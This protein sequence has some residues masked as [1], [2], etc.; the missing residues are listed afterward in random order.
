[1]TINL[2]E[3]I[4]SNAYAVAL[5]L[6]YL[7]WLFRLIPFYKTILSNGSK[8]L[9]NNLKTTGGRGE[10]DENKREANISLYTEQNTNLTW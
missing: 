2:P 8:F 9:S 6:N 7:N 4:L 10:K 1:M 5:F 3:R